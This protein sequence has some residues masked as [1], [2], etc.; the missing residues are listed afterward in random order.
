MNGTQYGRTCS[1]VD[2]YMVHMCV[3]I[4]IFSTE[5]DEESGLPMA[6]TQTTQEVIATVKIH[7]TV[8]LKYSIYMYNV[9]ILYIYTH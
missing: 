2:T 9:Y 7:L 5:E 4:C 3:H 8:L 1:Y 6:I